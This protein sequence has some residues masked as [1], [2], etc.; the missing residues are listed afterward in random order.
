MEEKRFDIV[1]TTVLL[2]FIRSFV[3]AV[4][5]TLMDGQSITVLIIMYTILVYLAMMLSHRRFQT[6]NSQA[7]IDAVIELYLTYLMVLLTDYV[8]D[9]IHFQ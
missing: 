2:P 7:R 4:S 1:V 9:K 6:G 8:Q 3:L 5:V